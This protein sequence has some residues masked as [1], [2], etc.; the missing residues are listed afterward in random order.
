MALIAARIRL[1]W[2]AVMENRTPSR[3]SVAIT[4]RE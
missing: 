1:S 2:R 3:R 4:A